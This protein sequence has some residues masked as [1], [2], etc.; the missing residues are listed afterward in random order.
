MILDREQLVRLYRRLAPL[1]DLL[2]VPLEWL[3]ARRY[4][5]R[6]V[7]SLGL[8]PGGVVLDLGCGTGL[9]MPWLHDAVGEGGRIVCVDLSADM[10]SRAR[11]RAERHG[12]T[13]VELIRADLATYRPPSVYD[14]ALAT[15]T[16]EVVPEYAEIVRR[17]SAALPVD[18]RLAVY[19]LKHPERWPAWLVQL[20]VWMTAPFGVSRSYE[21][22][23]PYEA[24]RE[25]LSEIGY[26]EFLF[27]VAYLCVGERADTKDRSEDR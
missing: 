26:R 10:L 25:H 9:N 23:R 12:F 24:V 27:G 2:V 16:L 5:E 3:G 21:T 1:Y 18:G 13:N 7:R 15:F 14:G 8:R 20:G 19:G 4:R 22:F 17:V 6:A 11:R